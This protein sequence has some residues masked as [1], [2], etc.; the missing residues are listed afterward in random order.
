M[1]TLHIVLSLL[2]LCLLFIKDKTYIK[3]HHN[4]TYNR[5]KIN[6][7]FNKQNL[8]K[9]IHNS[10]ILYKDITIKQSILETGNFKSN[11]FRKN[12]N[13]FGMKHPKQRETLSLGSK[14]NFANY[15]HW[16]ESIKDFELWQRDFIK[17]N[18]IKD[19]LEYI[20]RLNQVYSENLQYINILKRIKY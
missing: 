6:I 7:A 12:N 1:K 18:K 8:I 10:N 15:S 20:N 19:S 17:R 2:F 4:Q 9:H 5:Q 16:I 3:H 13:L 11:I 14:N